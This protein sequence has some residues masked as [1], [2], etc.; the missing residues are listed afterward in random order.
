M[1]TVTPADR[2]KGRVSR[3]QVLTHLRKGRSAHS[4]H[5][6]LSPGSKKRSSRYGLAA[7]LMGG[8]IVL[9]LIQFTTFIH[10]DL[11]SKKQTHPG[12]ADPNPLYAALREQKQEHA[13]RQLEND[14]V[15]VALAR[16]ANL[17]RRLNETQNKSKAMEAQTVMWKELR[18]RQKIAKQGTVGQ[19][20]NTQGLSTTN[21]ASNTTVDTVTMVI[22]GTGREYVL[23][24]TSL[25]SLQQNLKK[26]RRPFQ[27][28]RSV[29]DPPKD[30]GNRSMPVDYLRDPT[31]DLSKFTP[32]NYTLRSKWHGVLLDAGRHY[33]EVDWIYRMLDMLAI[34]QY[35]CLHFRLTDDQAWNV[36]LESQPGLA[37]PVGIKG[38]NQVYTPQQLRDI[39]AYAKTKGITIWPEINVP[40]SVGTTEQCCDGLGTHSSIECFASGFV[41]LH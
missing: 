26:A 22:N 36:Q 13:N 23:N 16:A 34:L 25:K 4:Q 5:H 2:R 18:E 29:P 39:V 41:M 31:V 28:M 32:T 6:P 24:R 19:V 40:V 9:V 14:G 20:Q 1:V 17:R 3:Q 8:I 27:L 10:H 38:H 37:H 30:F 21:T 15:A 35:N 33:F 12:L 11:D 7:L